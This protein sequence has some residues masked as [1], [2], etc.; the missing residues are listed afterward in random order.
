MK[1]VG[2]VV[3]NTGTE[4]KRKTMKTSLVRDLEKGLIPILERYC[5]DFI[6]E[7]MEYTPRSLNA[8]VET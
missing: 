3:L 4:T 5:H 1:C 6:C 7:C 2:R 8:P